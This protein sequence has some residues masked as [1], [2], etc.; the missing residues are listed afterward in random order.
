MSKLEGWLQSFDPLA[1][2]SIFCKHVRNWSKTLSHP[3]FSPYPPPATFL[4]SIRPNFCSRIRIWGPFCDLKSGWKVIS[5]LHIYL[6][7]YGPKNEF[8]SYCLFGTSLTEFFASGLW[9]FCFRPQQNRKYC[10]MQ[11]PMKKRTTK[12]GF[13]RPF[14]QENM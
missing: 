11:L 9:L 2:L 8:F 1:F 10:G 14:G 6:C 13:M 5:T 3:N 12:Y 4:V 7:R